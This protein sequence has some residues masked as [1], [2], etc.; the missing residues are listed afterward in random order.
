MY[1]QQGQEEIKVRSHDY[2]KITFTYW[3]Q[4]SNDFIS[5]Y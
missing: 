3:G 5:E 1:H 4:V 2:N